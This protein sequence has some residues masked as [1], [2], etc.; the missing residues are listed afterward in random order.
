MT[1]SALT[2]PGQRERL[3]VK[4]TELDWRFAAL[5]AFVACFGGL[6]LYAIA[7]RAGGG[8]GAMTWAGP[9]LIRFVFCFGMMMGLA[10][11]D[12]RIWYALSYPLYGLALV[13]LLAVMVV[14]T[15][16]LGAKRWLGHGSFAIQPSELMKIALVM[17]LSRYYHSI[18]AKQARWSFRL[19]IPLAM[20]MVPAAL[21]AK[22]PDLGTAIL[23]VATGV[24]V[25]ILAGLDW[26]AIAVAVVGVVAAAPV[27]FMFLMH[28]FQQK[29]ILTFL[30]PAADPSGAGY[31]IM[32]SE[33]A[34]GS[35]G[36]LGKGFLFGSQ[37][38]LNYLP[39]KETDFIF[40]SVA[41]Q[42]GFVGCFGL[43]LAYGLIVAM[44]LRIA[45]LSHSHY[46]R[47]SAAGIT[48]TFALYVLIN[49]AMVMG[50]APV[51]GVPMPLLSYGGTVM[52][53][54]MAGFG[55]VMAVRVNRYL[56]LPKGR[57][58]I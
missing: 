10:L 1:S 17:G 43:L 44:A 53:T 50:L 48:A 42:F 2:R 28:G 11:V 18:T 19:L 25:M 36:L 13:L 29:R 45:S 22:Q 47:L 20:I 31:H 5:I 23:L 6:I 37:A 30:N 4:V 52:M 58:L 39:E 46:G 51:V 33:I 34:L 15:S 7:A 27:F 8:S 57:G 38:S 3:T 24:V 21:V 9:H 16:H 55:L 26:R 12:L 35:G 32:Q 40:A 56:E 49:G 14:G 41:E 54:V